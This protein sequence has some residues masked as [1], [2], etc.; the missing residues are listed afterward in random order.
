[1]TDINR[2]SGELA[3]RVSA[4]AG[5][6]LTCVVVALFVVLFTAIGA[7]A[8]NPPS[9]QLNGHTLQYL[10]IRHVEV[11]MPWIASF[12]L[13]HLWILSLGATWLWRGVP[14][15]PVELKVFVISAC[16]ALCGGYAFVVWAAM[17]HVR[18]RWLTSW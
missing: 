7:Y 1:M 16:I 4:W 8:P 3:W 10:P 6:A 17:R 11:R 18:I 13:L 12:W 14:V 15:V 9:S 5:L 2:L